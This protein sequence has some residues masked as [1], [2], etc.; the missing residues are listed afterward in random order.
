M[1]TAPVVLRADYAH[2]ACRA[3]L[4]AAKEVKSSLRLARLMGMTV[5][6]WAIRSW[7]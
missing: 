7:R 5:P 1:R 2:V 4:F 6:G 3:A